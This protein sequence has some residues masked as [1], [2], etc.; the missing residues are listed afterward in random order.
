M[1]GVAE[2]CQIAGAG[3]ANHLAWVRACMFDRIWVMDFQTEFQEGEKK[4][5]DAKEKLRAA[6]PSS[7]SLRCRLSVQRSSIGE[8]A[9]KKSS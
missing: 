6:S 4:R 9:K 3:G 8:K 5:R 2:D 1:G 7:N